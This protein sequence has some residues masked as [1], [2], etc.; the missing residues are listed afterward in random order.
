MGQ[1]WRGVS[2]ATS[3]FLL[4]PLKI[5]LQLKFI[6]KQHR[7][8]PSNYRCD[9]ATRDSA[10]RDSGYTK[11]NARVHEHDYQARRPDSWPD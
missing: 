8:S 3:N 1:G 6:F 11:P 5:F 2:G 9:S 4:T 7:C 10:A